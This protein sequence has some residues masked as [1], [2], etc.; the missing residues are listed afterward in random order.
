MKQK[1]K[2]S[3]K[4]QA[5][6]IGLVFGV[7]IVSLM[8][9]L[10]YTALVPVYTTDTY[11]GNETVTMAATPVLVN[12]VTKDIIA[13]SETVYNSTNETIEIPEGAASATDCGEEYHVCYYNF[14]DGNKYTY[15][16]LVVN[17]SG[18]YYVSYQYYPAAYSKNSVDRSIVLFVGTFMLLGAIVAVAKNYGLM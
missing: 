7:I 9:P 17:Q 8:V 10:V 15:A 11:S 1:L 16:Q 5:S 2:L 4:G 14:T 13:G 12:L 18:D 6:T 3:R